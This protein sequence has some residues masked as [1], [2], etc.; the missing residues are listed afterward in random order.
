MSNLDQKIS[1]LSAEYLP[2]AEEIL[3]EAI[4]FLLL[5][6]WGQPRSTTLYLKLMEQCGFRSIS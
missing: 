5:R 6:S 2:L 3:K 1:A 4:L